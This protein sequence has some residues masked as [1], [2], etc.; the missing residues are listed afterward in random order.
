MSCKECK[1]G[2]ILAYSLEKSNVDENPASTRSKIVVNVKLNS[3]T[4]GGEQ[5]RSES[6]PIS[7]VQ[8]ASRAAS[9]EVGSRK[10]SKYREGKKRGR[11]SQCLWRVE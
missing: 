4:T 2:Q 1:Q 3:E 10:A 5:G 8:K 9:R 6:D 7:G 11:K